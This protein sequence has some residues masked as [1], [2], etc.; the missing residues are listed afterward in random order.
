MAYMDRSKNASKSLQEITGRMCIC[1][2][3]IIISAFVCKSIIYKYPTS[4]SIQMFSIIVAVVALTTPLWPTYAIWRSFPKFYRFSVITARETDT[5]F[6]LIIIAPI[7]T[8]FFILWVRLL[9]FRFFEIMQDF[10]T[11]EQIKPLITLIAGEFGFMIII[12]VVAGQ[13][14]ALLRNT[15]LSKSR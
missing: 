1:F 4:A 9:V 5:V 7:L 3:I 8:T 14:L 6:T 12:S 13:A 2:I 15:K 10:F 11:G